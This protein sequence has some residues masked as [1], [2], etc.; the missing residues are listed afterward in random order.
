MSS[1][2]S[3][4]PDFP[5]VKCK[6]SAGDSESSLALKFKGSWIL[7][8]IAGGGDEEGGMEDKREREKERRESVCVRTGAL[9]LMGKFPK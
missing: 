1:V 9:K 2:T 7:N 6:M 8:K 3:Q 4:S 5:A